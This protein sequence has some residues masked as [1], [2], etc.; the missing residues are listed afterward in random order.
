MKRLYLALAALGLLLPYYFFDR[1]ILANGLDIGL[2][3]QQLFTNDIST[4]FAVDLIITAIV[5]L[6]FSF[7][8]GKRLQMSNWW[9]YLAATLVIGPSFS[10]PTFLYVQ[11]GRVTNG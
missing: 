3:I 8:E 4:F 1:L 9:L 11:E 10:L 7:K 2:L 5:F 6:L